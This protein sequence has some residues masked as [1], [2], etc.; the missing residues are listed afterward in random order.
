MAKKNN[1]RVSISSLEEVIKER[2]PDIVTEDWYGVEVTIRRTLPLA[3]MVGF[4]KDIY[5]V[6][7]SEDGGFFPEAL[8]FAVRYGVLTRYAN[9]TLPQSIE[10]QYEFVY[11]CDAFEFV[12]SHIS[13]VQ[14]QK[15]LNAVDRKIERRCHNDDTYERTRL[16]ELIDEVK[17]L[18]AAYESVQKQ[19][20]DMFEGVN[21]DDLQNLVSAITE[22]GML[23]ADKVVEAYAR[24]IEATQVLYDAP[25]D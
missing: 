3:E 25:Q 8:D 2:F 23:D 7:F 18:V 4:T 5:D 13:T 6:C 12:T 21:A 1:K 24:N 14:L 16:V 19:M 22:D 10:K 9:F 17:N 11:G 20:S 15:I